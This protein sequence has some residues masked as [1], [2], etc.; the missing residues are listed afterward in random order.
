MNELDNSRNQ[1][2]TESF[3]FSSAVVVLTTIRVGLNCGN[4]GDALAGCARAATPSLGE[5][6]SKLAKSESTPLEGV[7]EVE[8]DKATIGG[9]PPIPGM[10]EGDWVTVA[11]ATTEAGAMR[12][13]SFEKRML[14]LL[15]LTAAAGTGE[16]SK[17]ATASTFRESDNVCASR[18]LLLLS[19]KP[20]EEET[21]SVT[22][23]V[24]TGVEPPPPT[25]TSFG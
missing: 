23:P 16:A 14:L 15:V 22:S 9:A 24:A 17:D 5:S 3:R 4:R 12:R 25:L 13:A 8:T 20:V 2:L 18:C 19:R 7:E 21:A 1:L 10:S 6:F 11:V